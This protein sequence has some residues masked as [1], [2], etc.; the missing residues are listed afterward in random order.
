MAYTSAT[1]QPRPIKLTKAEQHILTSYIPV[2][3]D[4]A[5]YLGNAYEIVLHSLEDFDHSVIAIVNGEH[6][7]RTVGAPITDLALD[8]L[9][10]LSKGRPSTPYF[11]TNKQG[12]PMKSTTIAIRGDHDRI[13]GLLCINLYLN[14]PLS[15]VLSALTVGHPGSVGTTET[16]ASD[17]SELIGTTLDSVR[18]RVMADDSILPS[19]KNKAIVEELY[20]KGMFRLK[21]AVVIAADLLGISKNTIYMHIRNYRRATGGAKLP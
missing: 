11:S 1:G 3:Q 21:D 18:R 6:T 19:N 10:A 7:G 2:V 12:D 4:L 9:N 14:T 20:L 8:M 13:I 5:G 16:F 15:D 17:T